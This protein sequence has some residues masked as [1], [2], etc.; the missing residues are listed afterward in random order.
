[1]EIKKKVKNPLKLRNSSK[2]GV[3]AISVSFPD[4]LLLW[5]NSVAGG[6]ERSAY[7]VRVIKQ[8]RTKTEEND[9]RYLQKQKQVERDAR[10]RLRQNQLR[11]ANKKVK[12]IKELIKTEDK[13]YKD[14]IASLKEEADSKMK[15]LIED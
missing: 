12:T 6:G 11:E 1:M 7:I 5:L 8:H 14:A 13:D 3:R 10:S 15:D 9:P 4:E 2:L